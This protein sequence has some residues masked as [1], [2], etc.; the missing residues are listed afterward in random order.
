MKR[1]ALI[2]VAIAGFVSASAWAPL[3]TA[4]AQGTRAPEKVVMRLDWKPSAQHALFYFTKAKG[5]YSQEGI[6]L[7]LLP[8]SGSSDALKLLGA[9][10]VDLAII[11]A[12]V[13]VQGVAQKVPVRAIAVYFQKSPISLISPRANPVTD[14]KQL[15]SGIKVGRRKA[16]ATYQ[17]LLA[18]LAAN[19]IAPEKV[20]MVDIGFGVQHL[21]VKQVDVMIGTSMTDPIEAETAG[22]PVHEI[23]IADAGVNTYGFTIATNAEMIGKRRDTLTRFLRATKKGMQEMAAEKVAAVQAVAKSADEID[24]PRETKVFDRTLPF[25]TSK[26]TQVNGFGWQTE[27]RWNETISTA[28]KLGLIDSRPA[29]ADVFTNEFLR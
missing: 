17:G 12:T 27:E 28:A 3:D 4:H 23:F 1:R 7:N 19:G 25:L 11:D 8:G 13:L 26:D 20:N 10:S 6:D 18:L 24:V 21:L 29:A 9:R 2:W 16:S 5:Y 14:I 15:T 22:M